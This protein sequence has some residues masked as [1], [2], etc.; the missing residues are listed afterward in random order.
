MVIDHLNF[1]ATMD[2]GQHNLVVSD[3]SNLI[4]SELIVGGVKAPLLYRGAGILADPSNPLVLGILT[5]SSSS[6]T[7]NPEEPIRWVVIYFF[8]HLILH[9]VHERFT[10]LSI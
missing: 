10:C 8:D 4:K 6:Y 2:A 5:G 3:A 9:S 1:D 7:H